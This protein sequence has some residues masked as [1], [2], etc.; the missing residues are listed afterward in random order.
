MGVFRAV[1][2]DARHAFG[3]SSNAPIP[4]LFGGHAQPTNGL[5]QCAAVTQASFEA[6]VACMRSSR[7]VFRGKLTSSSLAT[8]EKYRQKK[9]S[10]TR[11]AARQ[12]TAQALALALADLDQRHGQS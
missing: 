4:F 8:V 1:W 5:Q 2:R 12:S 11:W 10:F 9:H 7:I 6:V 3:V